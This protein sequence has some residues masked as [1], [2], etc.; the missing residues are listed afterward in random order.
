[1]RQM[2]EIKR[3][4]P[5][6][7]NEGAVADYIEKI[8]CKQA[9]DGSG[10]VYGLGHAIYTLSD[11]R[12]VLLKAKAAELAAADGRMDEFN[13]YSLIERLG[14]DV[15]RKVHPG[16][17]EICANV[18]LYSGFV[19]DM[20]NIPKEL[21]TPLF[22]IARVTGWCA[23]RLEELDNAGPIIRPAYKPI[24]KKRAYTPLLERV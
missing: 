24:Y 2:D 21:Y 12:A 13:L 15:I 19:Y 9:G 10:L 1:M 22:A 20:L 8:V 6:W 18:D 5:D 16:A 14:P 3:N 4:V 17:K 11:P 23:H 7:T